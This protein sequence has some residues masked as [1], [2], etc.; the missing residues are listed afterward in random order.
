MK[1]KKPSAQIKKRKII[2]KSL[3]GMSGQEIAKEMGI[4]PNTVSRAL[5]AEEMKEAIKGI[6]NRLA[7]GID[8]AIETVLR[9]VDHDYKA[10]EALLRNFGSMKQRVDLNHAFPAPL[11]IE[12]LDGKSQVV[13]GTENDI[14]ECEEG[15]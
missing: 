10:A 6:D 14:E 4:H 9:A 2:E 11:V 3:S 7:M 5:N 8:K 1:N 12:R 13:L 15:E